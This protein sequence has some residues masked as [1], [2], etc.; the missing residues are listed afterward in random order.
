MSF[1][2][3][4]N[5][6]LLPEAA[7]R[8][9]VLA[10][11]K[12]DD[13]ELVRTG[14]ELRALGL[15]KAGVDL[16]KARD[17]LLGAAIVGFYDPETAQLVV[18]GARLTPYIRTTLAHEI[19]HALQDQNLDIDHPEYDDR[20]DEIGI[21][22]SAVAEGDALRVEEAYRSSMS[23]RDQQDAAAE[24]RKAAGRINPKDIPLI[25]SQ[26]LVFPYTEGPAL[27]SAMLKAGGQARL[28]AAF[29]TPPTTTEQVMH[30]EK[31]LA[32]EGAKSVPDPAGDGP[33]IDKGVMGELL[34]KLLLATV[35][36]AET[37]A[38]AAAGWGGDRYVAWT[39]GDQTCIRVAFAMDT[40]TDLQELRS[41]LTQWVSKQKSASLSPADPPV[42]TACAA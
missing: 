18:R 35:L 2:R 13:A 36:P 10:L 6:E 5:V 38:R 30:P 19:T 23:R 21:G 8:A 24:E 32:G 7:F 29:K 1:K 15:L 22:F 33:A 37:A 16:V 42:L 31:F 26:L 9:R 28:D 39:Q 20:E 41:G 12:E 4:L 40:P 34:L 27:I 14:R 11:A 25:L 17:E 3:P